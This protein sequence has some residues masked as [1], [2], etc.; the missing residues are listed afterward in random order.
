MDSVAMTP[1]IFKEE[2]RFL[3]EVIKFFIKSFQYILRILKNNPNIQKY[4]I[5]W[6]K[7]TGLESMTLICFYQKD[8]EMHS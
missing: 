3:F 4:V 2:G 7:A 1:K 5:T 8:R 6:P